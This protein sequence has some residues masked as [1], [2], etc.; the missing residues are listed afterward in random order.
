MTRWFG[1]LRLKVLAFGIAMSVLPVSIY[2]WYGLAAARTAQVEVVQA[3]NQ[4][5][6]RTVS[7]ELAR[8]VERIT[9]QLQLLAR[10]EGAG[11]VSAP[12]AEQERV[13]YTLLRD[14][15]YLE[16]VS[17]VDASGAEVSRASRREV[18]AGQ[19]AAR[20]SGEPY[21]ADLRRGESVVGPVTFDPHG[22][23]LFTVGVPL[24]DG[25]GALIARPT[26][27]GLVDNL[28]AVRA[29]GAVRTH[30]IDETG[31]LIGDSDF[32][33]VLAGYRWAGVPAPDQP[34]GSL[35]GEEAFG[36]LAEVPGLGWR[37]LAETTVDDAMVPVRR[38]AWEFAGGALLM[39]SVVVGL[40][41]VFGLQ[42]TVPLERLEAG[43]VRV[44]S[45]D[46]SV[47]IPEGGRDELGRLVRAFN[48]M[49]E[50]LRVQ[51]ES[52]RAERDL[53][54][55]AVSAMGA[56]LALIDARGRIL[57]ANRHLLEWFPDARVGGPCMAV[58]GRACTGGRCA[59]DGEYRVRI[60]GRE[61]VLRYQNHRIAGA[62]PDGPARLEVIEDV[63]ERRA[64]EQMV[65][66]SEKLA[67]VGQLAA[68]V[69]HEI[70]NPLAVISAYAED[71]SD[72]LRDEGA[73]ALEREGEL[74]AYLAQLQFQVQRCKAITGN[75]LDF[76]RQGSA[77][78]EPVDVAGVARATA[79]LVAPRARRAG[80]AV[81]VDVPVAL[82]A[83]RAS[84]DQLQQVFLNLVTNALD[85][86]EEGGGGRVWVTAEAVA[87]AP[88]SEG[89]GVSD[90]GVAAGAGEVTRPESVVRVGVHDDGPGMDEDTLARA[91]DPFFTTKPPGR[92][93]GLGLS[94][95]YG[96]ITGLGG[97]FW[98]E[99]RRGQGTRVWFELPVWEGE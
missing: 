95:C 52:L 81:A 78:P 11:L 54:D 50:R 48:Q 43:A 30:V 29:G 55:T 84:R 76:A 79:A 57:W 56:G 53:L 51:G 96:I 34:Y 89:P 4:A 94:T 8:F 82:P 93:T 39:V 92:G 64:M 17:L 15:P 13:L 5:A 19:P 69:A 35:T 28:A 63:T 65:R 80:V 27:R 38:L 87:G 58:L 97:R 60:G 31:R 32:S 20:Y 75:L 66:Q 42:L 2:G 88:A 23:P 41:I 16:E 83:V 47:R 73:A 46:L 14:T 62:G 18:V 24:P 59:P 40:S 26:L 68:G 86:I 85:A 22:R 21:W 98:L 70:N 67:A 6:A 33:L 10:L 12:A 77:D 3:Q 90:I 9:G 7:E 71:L 45:G 99:S 37:V 36:Y 49:T 74:A 1:H 91:L 44:G 72:R 61:R 25:A